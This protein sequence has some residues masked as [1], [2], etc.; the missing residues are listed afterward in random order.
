MPKPSFLI[1]PGALGPAD[2]YDR[3][4]DLVTAKGYEI[5]ALQL[6][7]VKSRTETRQRSPPTMYA[8]VALIATE[9]TALADDGKDVVI[10]GHS[11]GGQPAT[12]SVRG[13][14]KEARSKEGKKGGIIRLAYMAALVPQFEQAANEVLGGGRPEGES[15]MMDLDEWGWI[16]ISDVTQAASLSLSE[17]PKEEGEYWAGRLTAHSSVAL[18]D[19]CRYAGWKDLPVSYLVCENDHTVTL[20]NQTTLIDMVERETGRNVDVMRIASGHAPNI[21]EPQLM[22]DWILKLAKFSEG[23]DTEG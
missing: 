22:L 14:T 23:P 12:E 13:L 17:L 9:A 1:V 4:V 7:S 11:Y 16:T 20:E 5:R 2:I 15:V 10:I 18:M 6:P 21:T 8:D 3:I 19:P